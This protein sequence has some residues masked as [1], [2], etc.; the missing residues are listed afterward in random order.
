[1]DAQLGVLAIVGLLGYLLG[2]IPTGY[3]V[4][5]SLARK[6]IREWGTG[7]IGTLN[8][9]RATNSKPLTLLTLAGDVLKG[10][11]AMV[12]GLVM[13][14]AAGHDTG[15]AIATGGIL[16]VVGHNY[17]VFLRFQGG[18][19][20]ATSLPVLLYLSPLMVALWIGV[21]LLTVAATR[22][23]VLGQILGTVAVPI[24]AIIFFPESIIPIGILA[25]LVF[26]RHAPRLRNI[27]KGTE[28]RL[29]YKIDNPSGH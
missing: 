13:T 12:V 22:L 5:K 8:T 17:S 11:L 18:K 29:Y 4:V 27:I 2:S 1:M 23:L 6:N 15:I 26:I 14:S 24:G 28:P 7:N 21:F 3:I 19:G 9:L 10:V 25:A 16:A 20:I